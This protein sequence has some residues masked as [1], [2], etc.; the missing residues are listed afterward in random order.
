MVNGGRDGRTEGQR[1]RRLKIPPCVLQDIGP[2][3]PLPCSH[4][5]TALNP[6]LHVRFKNTATFFSV[7]DAHMMYKSIAKDCKIICMA[8]FF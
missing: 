1:D 7:L 5:S 6:Y 8:L 2:L 3:G 4:L